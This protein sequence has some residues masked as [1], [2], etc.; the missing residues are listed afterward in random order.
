M[1]LE[2]LLQGRGTQ[3]VTRAL[4]AMRRAHLSHYEALGH[5]QTRTLVESLFDVTRKTILTREAR[6]MLA[7]VDRV[8][9][10]RFTRGFDLLEVQIAFNAL[11]ESIWKEV[12]EAMQPAELAE[13]LGLVSTA[14]GLGKDGLARG[15]VARATK[16]KVPSLD[17]RALFS[18]T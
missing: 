16:T 3:I 17:L 1:K 2:D 8:A 4:D 6:P 15:F 12:T 5:H 7:Y 11:E 9:E 14:L 18:G 10:E 13:S